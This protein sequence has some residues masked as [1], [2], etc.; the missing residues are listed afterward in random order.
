VATVDKERKETLERL[1]REPEVSVLVVGGGINGAGLFRELALQGVDVLLVEKSDFGAGAS[2]ASSRMIHGGLRYLEFGEFQLVKESVRERNLLLQN[3]PHFVRPLPTTITLF[4]WFSGI[5]TP[6]KRLLRLGGSRPARRGGLIVKLGLSLYDLYTRR[7]RILPKHSIVGRKK[8]FARRPALHPAIVGSARFHD[9]WISYPERL[10]LELLL[11]G[12]EAC[13]RARALNHVSLVGA[14]KETVTLRDETTGEQLGVRPRTVVN[15]TGGWIDLA[16]GRLGHDTRL[17][18]GT[19]GAH[20][21]LDHPELLEALQGEMVYFENI[22]GR[23]AIVLPWLGRPLLGST[24]IRIDDP[25][26]ARCEEG[27]VDY[28]LNALREMFPGLRVDRSQILSRFSGVRPLPSSD[29]SETVGVSR[30]HRCDVI[31]PTGGIAFPVFSMIGGKWTTFRGFG[32]HV[33]DLLLERLGRERR[34]STEDLAIGGGKGFPSGEVE[35]GRW[36]GEIHDRYGVAAKR[37]RALLDRYGVWAERVAAFCQVEEDRPLRGHRGYTVRE[38]EFILCHE[39]VLHLEDLVLRRTALAL[40]GELT[41]DLFD[42]LLA[43][44]ARAREWSDDDTRSE[45]ARTLEILRDRH[46]IEVKRTTA[47][48]SAPEE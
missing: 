22:D 24:D 42:E 32:E 8:T 16:N 44:M 46:G 10:C 4:S 17:M 34:A 2:G 6:I 33:A 35:L 47:T 40:L 18:G 11:D 7:N 19:K 21:V 38:I 36:L 13:E 5:T 29:A 25:D 48:L 3:A 14:S 31:E 12:E 43:I 1:R 15:A 41:A 28:M 26:E 23:V 39:R 9:A 20:L 37:A 30:D 27:E 45:G